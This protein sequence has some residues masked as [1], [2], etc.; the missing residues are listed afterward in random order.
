MFVTSG[1]FGAITLF[2][3]GGMVESSCG[4]KTVLGWMFA[5]ILA[6]GTFFLVLALLLLEVVNDHPSEEK[7]LQFLACGGTKSER[8]DIGSHLLVCSSCAARAKALHHGA[9]EETRQPVTCQ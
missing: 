6:F 7:L 1:I 5:F 3:M 4:E 9:A 2:S 8:A